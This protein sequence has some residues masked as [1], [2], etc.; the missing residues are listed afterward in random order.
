[1][2]S[3]DS[4]P[5]ISSSDDTDLPIELRQD[6]QRAALPVYADSIQLLDGLPLP[7]VSPLD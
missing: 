2:T 5:P 1:M 4:S 3:P 6:P 7:D